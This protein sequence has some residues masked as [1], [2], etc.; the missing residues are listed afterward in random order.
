[1]STVPRQ[2]A[3]HRSKCPNSVVLLK[4]CKTGRVNDD[5]VG[6]A[7]LDDSLHFISRIVIEFEI[8]RYPGTEMIKRRRNCFHHRFRLIE[9]LRCNAKGCHGIEA[10]AGKQTRKEN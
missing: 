10:K 8:S 7:F 2:G 9:S 6:L 4:G 5:C 3:L 1:M